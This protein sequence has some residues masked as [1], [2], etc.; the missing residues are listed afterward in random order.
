[1][2]QTPLVFVM[3]HC[4]DKISENYYFITVTSFFLSVLIPS[5][6]APLSRHLCLDLMTPNN[7]LLKFPTLGKHSVK[8]FEVTNARVYCTDEL[9]KNFVK[10]TNLFSIN[11]VINDAEK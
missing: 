8:R 3:I 2:I 6:H 11:V 10:S 4:T 1:M 5:N 9:A 7:I